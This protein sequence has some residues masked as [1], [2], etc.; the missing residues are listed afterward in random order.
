MA[1]GTMKTTFTEGLCPDPN[2]GGNHAGL[3]GGFPIAEGHGEKGLI[4]SP[5]TE[6]LCDAPYGK[7]TSSDK[8]GTLPTLTDI[9]DAPSGAYSGASAIGKLDNGNGDAPDST[10]KVGK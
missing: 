3:S 9:K 6:G 4:N 1:D 5:F 7:E 2:P 10:F 8:L